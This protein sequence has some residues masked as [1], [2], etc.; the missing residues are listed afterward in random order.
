[1]NRL[2]FCLR[3]A[4]KRAHFGHVK[5]RLTLFLSWIWFEKA[6]VALII[7]RTK[8]L[9]GG[10][11]F[12]HSSWQKDEFLINGPLRKMREIGQLKGYLQ[13][14][15]RN[16]RGQ[17][18]NKWFAPKQWQIFSVSMNI[19]AYTWSGKLR[20]LYLMSR[21]YTGGNQQ[22]QLSI[23]GDYLLL[24]CGRILIKICTP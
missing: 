15:L 21:S 5:P 12:F 7:D 20:F 8:H 17:T 4:T 23:T 16:D 13:K 14:N 11:P 18:F 24:D 6:T 19:I 3:A 1:M 9:F 22:Q 10:R 2:R